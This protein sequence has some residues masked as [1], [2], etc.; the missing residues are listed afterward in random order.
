MDWKNVEYGGRFHKTIWPA[1]IF[2]PKNAG[3]RA[4]M[5]NCVH[6]IIS[7]L[8]AVYEMMFTTNTGSMLNTLMKE[9]CTAFEV[10]FFWRIDS[11][12]LLESTETMFEYP[13][14]ATEVHWAGTKKVRYETCNATIAS[15]VVTGNLLPAYHNKK[16]RNDRQSHGLILAFTVS[17]LTKSIHDRTY[18]LETSFKESSPTCRWKR[19]CMSTAFNLLIVANSLPNSALTG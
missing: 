16:A 8:L 6:D 7:S 5:A 3:R 14:K 9:M 12:Y 19:I 15:M 10:T 4:S 11:F 18:G 2:Y 1:E 17:A 13:C